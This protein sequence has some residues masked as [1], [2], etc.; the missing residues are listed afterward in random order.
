MFGK[1]RSLSLQLSYC[2][3]PGFQESQLLPLHLLSSLLPEVIFPNDLV[4]R[5]NKHKNI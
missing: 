3:K 2:T 5:R 4:Q 1:P